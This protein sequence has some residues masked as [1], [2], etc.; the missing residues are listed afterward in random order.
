MSL[1]ALD[2]IR[3]QIQRAEK[4]I[5]DFRAEVELFR[6]TNPYRIA[7]QPNLQASHI[8]YDVLKADAIPPPIPAVAGDVLQNLRTALDYLACSLVPGCRQNLSEH[9]YFPILKKAPTPDQINTAFDGKVKGAS[10]EAINKI[11]SLKP[12]KGGDDVLWRLHML[13]NIHKH[14]LLIAVQAS[15]SLIVPLKR[16]IRLGIDE[17]AE[18][19]QILADTLIPVQGGF[20]LKQGGQLFV[21]SLLVKPDNN[22]QFL[23]EIAVNERGISEGRTLIKILKESLRRVSKIVSEFIP[24]IASSK[25]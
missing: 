22:V 4:H 3:S 25:C 17:P 1:D 7:S 2:D 19:E 21:D 6:A 16:P 14:R 10:E 24:L 11:A 23:V 8:I 13:N 12:Y 18:V 15:T 9:I 20:P 5:N